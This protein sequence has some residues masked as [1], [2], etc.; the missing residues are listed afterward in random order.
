[1]VQIISLVTK[2]ATENDLV[3]QCEIQ[4]SKLTTSRLK[5][6]LLIYL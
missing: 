1:M 3:K 6:D 2:E 5:K 4:V